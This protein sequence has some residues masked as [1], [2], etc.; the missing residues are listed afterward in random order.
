MYAT[1]IETMG[2][3]L[4]Q[5]LTP[6]VTVHDGITKRVPRTRNIELVVVRRRTVGL[7]SAVRG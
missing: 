3:I 5:H 4:M 7:K 6:P 2:N 1:L